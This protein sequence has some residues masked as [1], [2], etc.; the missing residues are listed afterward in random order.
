VA[1]EAGRVER[2]DVVVAGSSAGAEDGNV[3]GVVEERTGSRLGF[4]GGNSGEQ[5]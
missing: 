4:V 2:G 3:D 1:V 5:G